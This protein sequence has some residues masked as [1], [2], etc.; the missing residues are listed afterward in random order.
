MALWRSNE[1]VHA[2]MITEVQTD[3]CMVA[4]AAGHSLF[5]RYTETMRRS[6]RAVAVGDYWCIFKDDFQQITPSWAFMLNY[7]RIEY[8]A[9]S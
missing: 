2:G 4:C 3:G 1:T 5:H 8:P 9:P 7:T 6:G